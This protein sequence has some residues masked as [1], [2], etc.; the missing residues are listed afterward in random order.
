MAWSRKGRT[1]PKLAAEAT[2]VGR[3]GKAGLPDE[4][5][6]IE[7]GALT[8]KTLRLHDRAGKRF[9][10]WVEVREVREVWIQAVVATVFDSSASTNGRCLDR[11]PF[12]WTF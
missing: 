10:K 3:V 5:G 9:P 1:A 4:L 7:E 2:R 8:L 11:R 6:L 12:A